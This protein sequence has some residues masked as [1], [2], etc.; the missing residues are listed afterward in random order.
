MHI[1]DFDRKTKT[2]EERPLIC[3]L[4]GCGLQGYM[5]RG[6][7]KPSA[8]RA[9]AAASVWLRG[10]EGS[11]SDLLIIAI[12]KHLLTSHTRSTKHEESKKNQAPTEQRVTVQARINR[13]ST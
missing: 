2:N 11:S 7:N 13:L 6:H 1:Q 12:W 9:V 10:G 5:I 4:L 3:D 8:C